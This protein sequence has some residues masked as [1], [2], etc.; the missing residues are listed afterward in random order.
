MSDSMVAKSIQL[1]C[2]LGPDKDGKVHRDAEI[3]PMTGLVRKNIARPEVRQNVAKIVDVILLACL[4]KVGPLDR[5][6]RRVLDKLL[7]GDRDFLLL[8]IRKL[9]L[10]DSVRSTIQCGSCNEK[11]DI[12]FHLD[13]LPCRT[14]ADKGEG[15]EEQ[16]GERLFVMDWM[17]ADEKHSIKAKFRFPNGADQMVMA[18]NMHKNP[19]EAVY[20]MYYRCL[21]EWD[22]KPVEKVPATLFDDLALPVVD[23]VDAEFRKRMPGPDLDQKAVC[24]LCGAENDLDLRASD[25]LFPQ[26][27][28]RMSSA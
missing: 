24:S 8:E 4:K 15:I 2:G 1:P 25:F 10:G 6:D 5:I 18:G 13:R 12:T 11:S 27:R 16:N 20:Q 9:S 17:S 14:L 7:V 26:A 22:G 19:V 23:A 3:I 28:G 21:V